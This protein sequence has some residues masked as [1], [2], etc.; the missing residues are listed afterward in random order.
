MSKRA[1]FAATLV[2][3]VSIALGSLYA[4]NMGFTFFRLLH[5]QTPGVSASGQSQVGLPY[6]LPPHIATVADLAADIDTAAGA[7]V[8][9]SISRFVRSKDA[10]QTYSGGPTDLANDYPIDGIEGQRIQVRQSV[11]YLIVGSHDPGRVV[12]LDAQGT[13]GSVTGLTEFSFPYHGTATDVSELFDEINASSLSGNGVVSISR[14]IES[15]DGLQTYSRFPVDLPNNFPL[16]P[17]ES[18][19]IQVREDIAYVPLHY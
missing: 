11:N 2:V 5:E 18:Y 16:A 19:R 3:S 13:N 8:V 12:H 10:L 7:P 6:R 9:V 17:G 15:S 14:F 4:S 1:W